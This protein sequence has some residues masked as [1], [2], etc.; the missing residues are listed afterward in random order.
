MEKIID[1]IL[2]KKNIKILKKNFK[3]DFFKNDLID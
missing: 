3:L 1:E 2:K